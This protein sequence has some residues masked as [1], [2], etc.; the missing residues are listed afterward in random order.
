[1]GR[2]RRLVS[3]LIA[4][5]RIYNAA[6]QKAR[7]VIKAD[8]RDGKFLAG[9]QW[10]PGVDPG[11]F[12]F[13][14]FVVEPAATGLVSIHPVRNQEDVPNIGECWAQDRCGHFAGWPNLTDAI[15]GAT[16]AWSLYLVTADEPSLK[17][18]Y[19]RT[20]N[21]L[22]RAEKDA[23]QAD[24]GLFAGCSSFMESD[25]AYPAKYANKGA[26]LAKTVALS[27][28]ALYYQGY[29]VAGRMAD[30]LGDN[31]QA[32]RDKAK[33]LKEAINK[34]FWQED[35]G[36]YGYFLD[37][38][39]KLIPDMEGLGE[40]LCIQ[41]G[42]ADSQRAR[43]ILQSTPTTP[44]G[45]PC[46]WPQ[47]PEYKNYHTGDA[48]YYHNGMIWPFVQGYWARSA[49]QLGDVAI[50]QSEMQKLIKALAAERHLPGI[51]SS[52]GRAAGWFAGPALE[53][54]GLPVHGSEW[55][56]GNEF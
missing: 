39:K 26:M 47:W 50:F 46:L 28:A 11:Q 55:T 33:S 4:G 14:G 56:D 37:E 23:Q 36:Y 18:F 29:V 32:Y 8:I 52:G 13:H 5:R 45:L 35:K 19:Q 54:I 30:K 27:T 12:V 22:K 17:V 53:R 49:A 48:M 15:V 34:Y 9:K 7:N 44:F 40:A 2:R 10:A 21:S 41:F 31:G 1:M 6:Y 16:G 25:S 20:V 38:N 42:I 24:T 51:L 3:P 43:R